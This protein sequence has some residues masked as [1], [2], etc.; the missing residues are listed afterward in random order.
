MDADMPGPGPLL[1][2]APG[3]GVGFVLGPLPIGGMGPI[4]PGRLF[5][6]DGRPGVTFAPG[7]AWIH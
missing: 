2:V 3:A 5:G 1:G 7:L 6:I 4:P